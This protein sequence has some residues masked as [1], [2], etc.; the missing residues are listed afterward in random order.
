M[1]L[2]TK[3]RTFDRY[4]IFA[5]IIHHYSSYN[6]VSVSINYQILRENNQMGWKT[7]SYI[8]IFIDYTI[9]YQAV[10]H[11]LYKSGVHAQQNISFSHVQWE[12]LVQWKYYVCTYNKNYLTLNINNDY[13]NA[14][15]LKCKN[16][17]RVCKTFNYTRTIWALNSLRHSI[18]QCVLDLNHFVVWFSAKIT[19]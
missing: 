3:S 19:T 13:L 12:I 15:N 17:K 10:P 8:F 9:Q 7:I 4:S 2:N 5:L 14:F 1:F 11:L 18:H 6:L 16:T